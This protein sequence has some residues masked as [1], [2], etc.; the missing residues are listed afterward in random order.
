MEDA[1]KVEGSNTERPCRVRARQRSNVVTSS[2]PALITYLSVAQ[3]AGAWGLS[4]EKIRELFRDDDEVLKIG[5]GEKRF[6]RAYITLRIPESAVLRVQ[7]R[8]RR[9]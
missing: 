6:K 4:E 9:R 8:L 2:S 5:E 1:V 7:D 3:V